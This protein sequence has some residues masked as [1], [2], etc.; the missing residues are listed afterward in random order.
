MSWNFLSS[1]L[2]L[3]QAGVDPAREAAPDMTLWDRFAQSE[4]WGTVERGGEIVPKGLSPQWQMG[5]KLGLA[6][7]VV[8]LAYTAARVFSRRL[9]MADHGWKIGLITFSVLGALVITA[10]GYPPRYGIDLRG[11]VVLVYEFEKT[12]QYEDQALVNAL[13]KRI[14]PTGT[15]QITVRLVPP[16]KVEII[17][18]DV[19]PQEIE[20]IRHQVTDLG[21]LEFRI[22]ADRKMAAE[23]RKA[24][25]D[26]NIHEYWPPGENEADAK[27]KWVPLEQIDPEN[28]TKEKREKLA[29]FYDQNVTDGANVGASRGAMS[30]IYSRVI[31]RVSRHEE[32][33]M[34]ARPAIDD[35]IKEGYRVEV[36]TVNRP[37]LKSGP[38]EVGGHGN[39]VYVR[40]DF[41]QRGNPAVGFGFDS[42]G[43]SQFA[44]LTRQYQPDQDGHKYHLGI[45]LSGRLQNAPTINSIITAN[46]IIEGYSSSAEGRQE[47]DSVLAVLKAGQLPAQLEKT[48]LYE[49]KLDPTLGRDTIRNGL[50]SLAVSLG[51]VLLF[52]LWYYR[53]SGVVACIALL[54]NLLLTIAVMISIKAALTL[55]GLAGLVLTVGMA[56]DANVLIY[57]RMREEITRGASV[58]MAIRNGFA[59]A[60]SAIVDSNLTT[61]MTAMILY[62][63]GTEQIRG[64]SVTLILGIAMSMFTAI[65]VARVIFDIAEKRGWITELKMHKML[66]NPN[67]NFLAMAKPAMILSVIVIAVGLGAVFARGWSDLMDIDFTGGTSTQ[68]VFKTAEREPNVRY[69]A[70]WVREQLEEWNKSVD[71]FSLESL[72]KELGETRLRIVAGEFIKKRL[73]TAK[74]EDKQGIPF[75]QDEIEAIN[76]QLAASGP[77]TPEE[78]AKLDKFVKE[79]SEAD[80]SALRNL[81][82]LEDVTVT[83]MQIRLRDGSQETRYYINTTNQSSPAVKVVLAQIFKDRLD[84][85][86]ISWKV[87]EAADLEPEKKKAEN[88]ATEKK[89]P[90]KKEPEKAEPK[91]TDADPKKLEPK[92]DE[93]AG[94]KTSP[95]SGAILPE[96]RL[97]FV[98]ASRDGLF[99]ENDDQPP[100][101]DPVLL[102]Q[103]ITAGKEKTD[104]PRAEKDAKTDDKAKADSTKKAAAGPQYTVDFT[105]KITRQK[106]MNLLQR[107]ASE[108]K[109]PSTGIEAYHP[110]FKAGFR[111]AFESWTVAIPLP[112]EQAERLLNS[113]K[114]AVAADPRFPVS[115]NIDSQVSNQMQRDGLFAL[116][117]SLVGIVIYVWV[118]F[119]NVAFGLAAVVALI[120]DVL[121][122]LG[123]IALSRYLT[124]IPTIDPFKIN[125]DIVAAFLTIIGYSINDTIVIFDRIREV[126]GKAP[127]IT[128]E[129]VNRSV[130]Q[131]LSRTILT[132]LT[133]FIVV[134]VL[135]FFGGQGLHGFSFALIVGLIS[136]TYSTVYIA[137]P[138][139]LWLIN[140]G[141]QEATAAEPPAP[142]QSQLYAGQAGS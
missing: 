69:D 9:R 98:S 13:R 60:M 88:K 51:A 66:S 6:V 113:V 107:E 42:D 23:A 30:G 10:L 41:D 53:F 100:L 117:A 125:L 4:I 38:Q 82:R 43:A 45:V 75:T 139:M 91:K 103:A 57:E 29:Q 7:L 76:N 96:H 22:L 109:I 8:V 136:G 39:L 97:Y 120:H 127:R 92:K 1:F 118:R 80:F 89:E 132:S 77:L 106:L 126:R 128:P 12:Q 24:A 37:Y 101:E 20:E 119:Q 130:N 18:P 14:D 129:M 54:A 47:R 111:E 52:V 36:L 115:V 112:K 121:V 122:T 50:I 79:L 90:E 61:I 59:K 95:K 48:P 141:P 3:A 44:Y 93:K 94:D 114:Q 73:I 72:R 67:F 56:V 84:S 87:A 131:T 83:P 110:D 5:I 46:G 27:F 138:V 49:F 25:A 105:D 134:V 55:P 28:V 63:V 62:M 99:A 86:E 16:N 108:Q 142:H 71:N 116:L 137:S 26:N 40:A 140:R 34:T 74:E 33:V 64:F 68:I 102:A 135:Y 123:F 35:I 78:A 133:V 85:E 15:K 58:R 21:T 32:E 104:T 65:F 19:G 31:R 81:L 11:G 124:G 2:P 70:P 17:V